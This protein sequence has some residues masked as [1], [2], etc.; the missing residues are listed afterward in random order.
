M[1]E[2]LA[3]LVPPPPPRVSPDR[4][5]SN[6]QAR[7]SLVFLSV[8]FLPLPSLLPVE[9]FGPSSESSARGAAVAKT[10]L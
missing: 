4:S 3:R 5:K 8:F 7:S 9:L 6:E 1:T 2:A 10:F